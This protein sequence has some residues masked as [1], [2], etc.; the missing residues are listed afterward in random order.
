ME[1]EGDEIKSK[2]PSKR[3][4][5]LKPSLFELEDDVLFRTFYF[6]TGF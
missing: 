5:T 4:R 3:G 1:G 2:Q 6:F